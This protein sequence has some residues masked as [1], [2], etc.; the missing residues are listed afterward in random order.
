MWLVWGL[1]AAAVLVAGLV[2]VGGYIGFKRHQETQKELRALGET[3]NELIQQQR[4]LADGTAPASAGPAPQAG[5]TVPARNETEMLRGFNALLREVGGRNQQ[6]QA[7]IAAEVK[8]L[9]LEQAL[10]PERLTSPQG[11]RDGRETARRYL[12]LVERSSAEGLQARNE[13]RARVE[14]L[15]S[16]LPNRTALL[17]QYDKSV[18]ARVVLEEQATRNQREGADL[19]LQAIE[20]MERIRG[21]VQVQDGQ[22]V[23]ATQRDLD[24]YNSIIE[25]IQAA[26]REEERLARRNDAL[27][28]QAQAN[29]Q[30]I[31]RM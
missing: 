11:R 15:V 9:Q 14:I 27:L 28:N 25:R 23:F 22:L 19:L 17:A 3:G 18:S 24:A 8:A 5:E 16:R 21:R 30:K 10:A 26:G 4:R 20:L 12:T 1:I 6:Q 13:L 29:F 31:N 7:N 2:G